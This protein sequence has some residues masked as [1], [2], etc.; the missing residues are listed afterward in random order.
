MFPLLSNCHWLCI[1]AYCS[2]VSSGRSPA[3]RV[4]GRSRAWSMTWNRTEPSKSHMSPSA[5]PLTGCCS[6]LLGSAALRCIALHAVTRCLIWPPPP[7]Q[8]VCRCARYVLWEA[9]DKGLLLPYA[10]RMGCC[11][12]CAVRIKE[13]E[14]YQP[15]VQLQLAPQAHKLAITWTPFVLNPSLQIELKCRVA[16]SWHGGWYSGARLLRIW[17]PFRGNQLLYPLQTRSWAC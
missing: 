6:V 10:C 4:A 14:M 17:P 12:A 5:A 1:A 13:G 3:Y 11:T 7:V 2:T 8:D 9:E 16:L 15:Q